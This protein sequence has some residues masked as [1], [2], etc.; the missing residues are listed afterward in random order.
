VTFLDPSVGDC[1]F[2]VGVTDHKKSIAFR[3]THRRTTIWTSILWWV[4]FFLM[5]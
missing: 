2:L 1:R 5:L 3:P 4:W